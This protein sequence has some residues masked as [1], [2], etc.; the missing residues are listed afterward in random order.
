MSLF[1][2]IDGTGRWVR[3][4]GSDIFDT[5]ITKN[6]QRTQSGLVSFVKS[7]WFILLENIQWK[8]EQIAQTRSTEE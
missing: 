1:Y 7:L 5:K 3:I 4:R 6:P 8:I 2:P